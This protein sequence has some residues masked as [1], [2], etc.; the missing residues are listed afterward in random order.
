MI[1][2]IFEMPIQQSL[3]SFTADI[4]LSKIE[5][6]VS[7]PHAIAQCFEFIKKYCPDA[8]LHHSSSTAG[9]VPLA[10]ALKLPKESTVVIGHHGICDYFPIKV[11]EKNIHDQ[12]DNKTQFCL[13]QN[14]AIPQSSIGNQGL[15][16]FSTPKDRPGSLLSV[17]DIF[18]KNKINLTKILS[19]PK[20][21]EAGAYVFYIEFSIDSVTLSTIELLS[22]VKEKCLFLRSLGTTGV[23]N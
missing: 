8:K 6:I 10:D 5:H 23:K 13:I 19:R 3:L 18:Y 14:Y 4:Q 1:S 15:I 20:K 16:A 21:S 2:S 9:S 22:Q 17:L 12:K 7:M 11:R